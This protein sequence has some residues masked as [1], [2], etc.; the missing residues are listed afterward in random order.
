MNDSQRSTAAE[1][2]VAGFYRFQSI[3]GPHALAKDLRGRWQGRA[4][5]GTVL[6]AEEGVNGTVAGPASEVEALLSELAGELGIAAGT[7]SARRSWATTQP[8]FRL[9]IRAKREIVSLRAEDARPD[10]QVGTY[11]PPKEWNA[12]IEDPDVLVIDTRNEYEV[13]TGRFRGA[14]NP[15]TDSFTEFPDYVERALSQ[16]KQQTVAMYCTGG[17]RCEKATSLL[18]A[19]GFRDVRHLQGGILAYLE[20]VPEAD[21]LWE[22]DCFVFD[23]RVALTHGLRPGSHALC[24]AC[25]EPLSPAEQQHPDH[26]AGV[27]CVYCRA[28]QTPEQRTAARE[29]VRQMRLAKERKQ[30]HIG[31]EDHR[32]HTRQTQDP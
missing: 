6:V 30:V 25:R 8:F 21:S 28:R 31:W 13:R 17:I 1:F 14:T 32:P 10:L 23:H 9:K 15:H 5:K 18:L 3:E 7:L 27:C 4:V 22:G 16:N 20:Q 24:F 11:V 12:L 2:L 26:E 19:R 29:R